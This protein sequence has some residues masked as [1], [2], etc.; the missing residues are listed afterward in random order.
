[1]NAGTRADAR[2]P[3]EPATSSPKH[4]EGRAAPGN[5]GERADLGQR[6][7]GAEHWEDRTS[8]PCEHCSRCLLRP[9]PCPRHRGP[10]PLLG[11]HPSWSGLFLRNAAHDVPSQGV[12]SPP[13]WFALYP[14][15]ALQPRVPPAPTLAV[16]S[17]RPPATSY[18]G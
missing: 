6:G 18:G 14:S 3:R 12:L 15:F 10:E 11:P 13:Q 5:P 8:G 16:P 1:M 9:R 17:P 7:G 2:G 4:R